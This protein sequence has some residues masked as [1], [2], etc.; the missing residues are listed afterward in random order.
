MKVKNITGNVF[1][2]V[3]I[4]FTIESL[5]EVKSLWC[6]LGIEDLDIP[7]KISEVYKPKKAGPHGSHT[8]DLWDVIDNILEDYKE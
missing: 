6:K 8:Y 3:T 7:K 1:N 5:D 4:K 2:P